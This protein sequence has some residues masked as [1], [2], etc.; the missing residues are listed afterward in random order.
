MAAYDPFVMA[1][2][3]AAFDGVDNERMGSQD[4]IKV[5]ER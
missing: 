4:P 3:A 1:K 5:S 2:I